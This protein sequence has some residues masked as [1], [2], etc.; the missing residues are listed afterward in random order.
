LTWEATTRSIHDRFSA[1]MYCDC[2][3][4]D[5]QPFADKCNLSICVSIRMV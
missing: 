4:F 3:L 1:I 2:F 5:S